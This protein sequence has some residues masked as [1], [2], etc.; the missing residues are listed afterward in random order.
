MSNPPL[1]ADHAQYYDLLCSAINYA[2]QSAFAARA[3]GVFGNGGRNYLDLACGSGAHIAQMLAAGYRCI[4]VDI[5]AEMLALAKARSSGA[6]FF[7]QD[8]SE[9]SV[10]ERQDLVTCFLYSMHYCHPLAKFEQTLQRV[11]A[12]LR[13]GGMFCFDAVDKHSVANDDGHTHQLMHQQQPLQFQTRWYYSGEG[14]ALDLH[15]SI[16]DGQQHYH[17][18]HLMGA[19]S[20]AEIE[21][22]LVKTGFEVTILE[23]DFERLLPWQGHNGNVI[24]CATKPCDTMLPA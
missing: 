1:Y 19:L 4:G 24:F 15:I 5:S 3:N 11:Y 10:S 18:Q 2:E 6:L 22:M 23:R 16:R 7:L 12:A 13:P 17:E 20:I 14:D 21:A 9:L 8:M